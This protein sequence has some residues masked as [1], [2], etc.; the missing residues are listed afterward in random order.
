MDKIDLRVRALE[1]A[2][3]DDDTPQIVIE[4]AA[5]YLRFLESREA[6]PKPDH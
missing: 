4:R 3:K 2:R 6:T 1:L 5:L